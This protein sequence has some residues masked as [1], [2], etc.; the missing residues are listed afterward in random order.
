MVFVLV[1]HI[2]LLPLSRR[3]ITWGSILDGMRKATIDNME[4]SRVS[5]RDLNWVSYDLNPNIK[6]Y[7]LTNL[8]DMLHVG[9]KL[10]RTRMF[11][12]TITIQERNCCFRTFSKWGLKSV[13]LGRAVGWG[14]M[15]QA[16]RSRVRFP[17]R[18]LDFSI[19]LILPAALC[20]GVDP[21]SNR[22]EYQEYVWG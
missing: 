17:M 22:N 19:V 13:C 15:L 6:R 9:A 20:P 5:S 8:T 1:A 7:R 12:S 2:T 10:R 21:V 4:Y 14:T 11:S 16:G 3:M 18:S